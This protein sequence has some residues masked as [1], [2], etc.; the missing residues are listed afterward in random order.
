MKF[1]DGA[2][3]EA[4]LSLLSETGSFVFR[5][6]RY[7]IIEILQNGNIELGISKLQ[8]KS[9]EFTGDLYYKN[10]PQ[11]KLFVNEN[12]W[13]QPVGW[14]FNQITT[15]GGV[16]LLGG[17]KILSRGNNTKV[18][19]DLPVHKM[20]RITAT[21]HF[22]DGW[23]GEAAYLMA[24]IGNQGRDEYLW[25]DLYDS[26]ATG[27]KINVCGNAEVGEGKFSVP[28]DVVFAHAQDTI[29]LTFGSKSDQNP[30]VESWGISNLSIHL[31]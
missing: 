31:I 16:N 27:N 6:D 2:G 20:V 22:I 21:F 23:L 19:K 11:W 9:L 30:D 10:Q 18:F 7:N 26:H 8:L 15:C 13:T 17:Y 3:H 25:T 24:N 29:K 5:N 14:D 1:T 4:L 12:Y 28:I